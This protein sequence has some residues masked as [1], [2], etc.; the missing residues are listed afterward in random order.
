MANKVFPTDFVAATSVA[1]TDKTII[2]DGATNVAASIALV[3]ERVLQDASGDVTSAS[4]SSVTVTGLQGVT[5]DAAPVASGAYPVYSAVAGQ[6]V[7]R[8]TLV[9]ASLAAAAAAQS[10][11]GQIVGMTCIV[12][13]SATP[14]E[15]GSYRIAAITGNTTDY[16][17]I[18]DATNQADE[19][20]IAAGHWAG[21]SVE[22]MAGD[23]SSLLF[24]A[25]TP[26]VNGVATTA[27]SV[28][29]D[30]WASV[31]WDITLFN[32]TTG[33]REQWTV[34]ATHDGTAA[35][36]ATAVNHTING[37]GPDLGLHTIDV[38]L[39]GTGATQ[40][41]RLRVTA[42]ATGWA[43]SVLT[44]TQPAGAA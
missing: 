14:S 33:A 6:I 26:L 30:Q 29:V 12:Y 34:P 28:L 15:D 41:M 11:D 36:D 17:K 18:S 27:G 23:L 35:A 31:W 37:L 44:R 8:G 10:A 38:D 2:D 42:G 19:V 24:A 22:T 21:S 9:Y 1:S 4:G 7:W 3:G 5:I 39:T 32:A 20:S 43:S 40:A 13:L 16:T 25:E